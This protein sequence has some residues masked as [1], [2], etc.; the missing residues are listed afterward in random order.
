MHYGVVLMGVVGVIIWVLSYCGWVYYG[1]QS[2][3]C[4]N[5]GCGCVLYIEFILKRVT[6]I[7]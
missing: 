5:G 3:L 1:G 4:V 2:V 7:K 6:C